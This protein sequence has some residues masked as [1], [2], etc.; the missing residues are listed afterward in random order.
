MIGLIGAGEMA[1]HQR[2]LKAPTKA[3][4]R[5]PVHLVG[6]KSEAVHAGVDMDGAGKLSPSRLAER[7]PF[8]DLIGAVQHG[9]EDRCAVDSARAPASARRARRWSRRGRSA[10]SARPS[11]S[12]A[13]KK[14]LQPV[15]ARAWGDLGTM[16]SP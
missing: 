1:H 14:V 5:D 8:F 4:R 10:R 3:R 16:P 7:G 12:V 2:E 6:R 9:A 11:P 15:R 13:T